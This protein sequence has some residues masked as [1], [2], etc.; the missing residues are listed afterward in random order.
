MKQYGKVLNVSDGY[1]RV[2]YIF[3]LLW[4]FFVSEIFYNKIY[5]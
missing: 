2:F 3:T 4:G 1:M 5:F